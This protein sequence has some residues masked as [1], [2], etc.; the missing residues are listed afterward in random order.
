M[1]TGYDNRQG[2]RSSFAFEP[3]KPS[4]SQSAQASGFRGIQMDGGN[5][6]VAGGISAASN[7]T[8]AGPS[9][10]ALGGFFTELLAPAI[11][12]RQDEL[13]VKGMVDQM[14]AVSGE[15]IRVNNKNPINQIFGPVFL[16]GRRY[17]LLS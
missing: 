9:A 14:S 6:S 3:A 4:Q 7:F 1:A 17:R 10:G 16:R 11:K 2:G 5:T 15:E 8:E 12:R 13:F